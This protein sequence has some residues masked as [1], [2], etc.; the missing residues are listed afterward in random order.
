MTER[1]DRQTAPLIAGRF[2]L[3]PTVRAKWS[4]RLGDWPVIG[5]GRLSA[6]GRRP[7]V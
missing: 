5:A 7:A 2:Y 4:N 1:A 3:A 6:A